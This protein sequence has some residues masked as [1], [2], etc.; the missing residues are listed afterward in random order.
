MKLKEL[1]GDAFPIIAKFAPSIGAAIGGPMGFA[2][3]YLL[4]VLANTFNAHP[5]NMQELVTNILNDPNT[6]GKLES[7]EHEHGDWLCT[8]LDSIGNLAEAEINIKLKWQT[9]KEN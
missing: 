7:I 1:L 9:D 4:P 3:G 2:A 6:Q 5:T 8:T